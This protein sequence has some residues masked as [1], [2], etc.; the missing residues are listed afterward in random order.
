MQKQSALVTLSQEDAHGC[1]RASENFIHRVI[2]FQNR[3]RSGHG[4]M[5]NAYVDENASQL[6]YSTV[7]KCQQ[8][9]K[10]PCTWFSQAL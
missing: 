4:G 2:K 7:W 8:V 6:T 3:S 9:F 5:A 1:V 10:A